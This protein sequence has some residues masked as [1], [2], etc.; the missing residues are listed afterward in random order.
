MTG[1]TLFIMVLLAILGLLMPSVH[2]VSAASSSASPLVLPPDTVRRDSA[3]HDAMPTDTLREVTVQGDTVLRVKQIMDSRLGRGQKIGARS[4]GDV[5]EKLSPGINDKITHPFAIKQRKQER[6]KK[7]LRKA[8]E[9]YEHVK[10][11]NELLDEAVKRQQ[12][13]DERARREAGRDD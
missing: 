10:T 7:K 4:V 2:A 12:M 6:R 8:L 5:L 9:E 1:H 11:F 13:E 3:Q